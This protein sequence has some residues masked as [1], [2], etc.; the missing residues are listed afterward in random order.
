MRH[1]GDIMMMARKLFSQQGYHATSM[2]ELA[3]SLRIREATLY[4]HITS[5]EEILWE[6]VHQAAQAFLSQAEAVPMELPLEE[7]LE[8]L[9]YGHLRLIMYERYS[10]TIFFNDWRCLSPERQEKIKELRDA[11]EAFF[12]R[13]IEEGVQAGLFQVADVRLATLFVLSALNWTYQWASPM[14]KLTIRQLAGEYCILIM[15][16][17]K[18]Q[19]PM[20]ERTLAPS[21]EAEGSTHTES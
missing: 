20:G 4:T 3:R 9:V 10:T 12:Q 14:R 2:R 18:F 1:K 15:Q 11:Y 6:I 21:E 13:V 16:S 7:Q 17:L 5:K 8:R 19:V